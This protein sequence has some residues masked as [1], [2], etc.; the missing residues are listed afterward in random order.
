MAKKHDDKAFQERLK[1]TFR[2]RLEEQF[3]NGI[4]QG[5]YAA[6]KVINDRANAED[7]TPEERLQNIIEFCQ[8]ALRLKVAPKKKVDS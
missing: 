8:P 4:A 3:R 7:K 1:M 2:M 6:C 5:M